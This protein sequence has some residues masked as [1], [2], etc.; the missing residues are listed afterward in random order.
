MAKTGVQKKIEKAER[1][2]G[3]KKKA[4][5]KLRM[6]SERKLV[7]DYELL[8]PNNKPVHL[9]KLFGKKDE[10]ILVHNMG[11]GCSYCALWADG[12]NGMLKHLEDR[13]GFAVESPD[14]PAIQQKIAK[15]RGWKFTFVSSAKS[16]FRTD[17]GFMRDGD[18]VPGV[19][20]FQRDKSGKI[21]QVNKSIFGPGDNYC[22]LWDLFDLLPKGVN[23]WSAKFN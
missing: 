8:G 4:L 7:P 16:P 3:Q 15:K 1:E 22:P 10:L 6:K 20:T 14:L 13:A 9:S 17:I 21:Y 5:A 19:S 23:G 11:K 12:F 2:I 18:P